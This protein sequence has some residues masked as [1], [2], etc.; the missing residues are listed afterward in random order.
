M[1]AL[2]VAPR[3]CAFIEGTMVGGRTIP[4]LW[5]NAN[6]LMGADKYGQ[7]KAMG[8]APFRWS[9][10]GRH[11]LIRVRDIGSGS[12]GKVCQLILFLVTDSTMI[13]TRACFIF[14]PSTPT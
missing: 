6:G 12:F 1:H 7:E 10:R 14:P 2:P 9:F 13:P 3:G 11:S 4:G 8:H 5:A